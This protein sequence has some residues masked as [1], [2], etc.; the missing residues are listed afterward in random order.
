[1]DWGELLN[2]VS[3]LLSVIGIALAGWSISL[4]LRAERE[5]RALARELGILRSGEET[6]RAAALLLEVRTVWT[7]TLPTHLQLSTDK[8]HE[9]AMRAY[10]AFLRKPSAEIPAT[11]ALVHALF[12]LPIEQWEEASE[13]GT[14]Q[15]IQCLTLKAMRDL[16]ARAERAMQELAL[17]VPAHLDPARLTED[18]TGVATTP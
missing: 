18:E 12:A 7:L 2:A 5:G 16:N 10:R 6:A 14:G 8:T 3:L 17:L 13:V 9:L 11:R 15:P 1:M 4:A